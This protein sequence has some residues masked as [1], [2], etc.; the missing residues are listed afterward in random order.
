MILTGSKVQQTARS[1]VRWCE[2]KGGTI[3]KS[4]LV[5]RLSKIGTSG[6]HP[7]NAERDCHTL[8]KSFVRRLGAKISTVRARMYNHAEAR[9]E[10]LPVSVIYPDDMATAFPSAFTVMT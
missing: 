2:A 3:E 1:A 5:G 9:V 10:L 4:D 6:K 7:K 8:L